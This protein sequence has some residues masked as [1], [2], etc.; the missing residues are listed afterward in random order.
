M[1]NK[2]FKEDVDSHIHIIYLCV[3]YGKRTGSPF[4]LIS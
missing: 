2:L 3:D 4:T 1:L